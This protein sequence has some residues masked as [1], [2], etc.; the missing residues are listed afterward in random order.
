MFL[1]LRISCQPPRRSVSPVRVALPEWPLGRPPCWFGFRALFVSFLCCK[2]FRL[3]LLFFYY[4][5]FETKKNTSD[6]LNFLVFPVG[7]VTYR[8]LSS[9]ACEASDNLDVADPRRSSERSRSSSSNWMRRLRAATS[10][11]AYFY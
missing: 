5:I 10:D 7:Q 11:S 9:A 6:Y 4:L 2:Y 3:N 8:S 1:P